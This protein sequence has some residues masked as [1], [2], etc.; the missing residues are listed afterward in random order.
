MSK[1]STRGMAVQTAIASRDT[2][3]THGAL[4]AR[5]RDARIAGAVG[6]LPFE[7]V[8]K[9]NAELP[10]YVVFSYAT[11]IAWWSAAHGWTIPAVKYSATTSRH[12]STARIATT[13]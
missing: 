5:E 10:T 11:P 3:T 8:E 13:L 7:Y 9:F 4:H 1:I 6:E 2:F 12:Q